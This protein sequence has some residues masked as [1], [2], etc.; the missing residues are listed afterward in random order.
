MRSSRIYRQLAHLTFQYDLQRHS[1]RELDLVPLN[2]DRQFVE[3]L[4]SYGV[5][6]FRKRAQDHWLLPQFT[7]AG[8]APILRRDPVLRTMLRNP[9]FLAAA[10]AIRCSTVGLRSATSRT[11]I[12]PSPS[13][14]SRCWPR[15]FR[16]SRNQFNARCV[17]IRHSHVVNLAVGSY[18]PRERYT[19]RNT[20]C[21]S[22]S[23]IA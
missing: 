14:S 9:G 7:V 15:S 3:F 22:S 18:V 20:S 19:R 4:K 6:L 13:S 23:D 8:V 5:L 21:A 17:A 10:A 11:G 1:H 2:F 16:P 12:S